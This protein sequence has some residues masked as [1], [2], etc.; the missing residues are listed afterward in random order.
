VND[1]TPEKLGP[2]VSNHSDLLGKEGE[3][4]A[5]VRE[6]AQRIVKR[7][8]KTLE[9]TGSHQSLPTEESPPLT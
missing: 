7:V 2:D 9:D 4:L 5:R 1:N 8:R 6:T 3:L